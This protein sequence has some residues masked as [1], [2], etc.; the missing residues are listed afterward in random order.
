VLIAFEKFRAQLRR[1]AGLLQ[2]YAIAYFQTV[3]ETVITFWS[4]KTLPPGANIL[5][6]GFGAFFIA[7]ARFEMSLSTNPK[8]LIVVFAITYLYVLFVCG[9][10]LLLDPGVEN[11]IENFKKL[12]S[13]VSVQT[14]LA[15]GLITLAWVI[16]WTLPIEALAQRFGLFDAGTNRLISVGAAL[17]ATVLILVRTIRLRPRAWT[18]SRN[19][20]LVWVLASFAI[21]SVGVNLI[22]LDI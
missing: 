15:C 11:Q 6:G 19:R 8:N 21:V 20:T 12:V 3:Y 1:L 5:T 14:S 18:E 22:L 16:P 13:L 2:S 9:I 10:S 17:L 7:A 4:M